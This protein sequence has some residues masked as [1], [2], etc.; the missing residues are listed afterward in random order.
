M[1]AL[2]ILLIAM[3][4][5]LACSSTVVAFGGRRTTALYGFTS[6]LCAFAN[7]LSLKHAPDWQRL[8]LII[9][10][11]LLL[12]A[13]LVLGATGRGTRRQY[14]PAGHTPASEPED[15]IPADYHGKGA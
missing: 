1:T 9:A 4:V 11:T 8:P 15:E 3:G 6:A 14:A 5:L 2:V 10:A 12:A 13:A 7:A